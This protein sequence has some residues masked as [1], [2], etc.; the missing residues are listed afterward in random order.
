MSTGS[1]WVIGAMITVSQGIGVPTEQICGG[2]DG[3]LRLDDDS[4]DTSGCF[5]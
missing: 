3:V 2:V 1:V 4:Q 5:G